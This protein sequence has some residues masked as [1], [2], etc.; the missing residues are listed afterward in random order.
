MYSSKQHNRLISLMVTSLESYLRTD[1]KLAVTEDDG[2]EFLLQT[3][4]ELSESI[5]STY[6]EV[7]ELGYKSKD[8]IDTYMKEMRTSKLEMLAREEERK[9]E[10]AELEST[11]TGKK[12][13]KCTRC[14]GKGILNCYMHVDY[15]VCYK[16]NGATKVFSV[17]YKKHMNFTDIDLVY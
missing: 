6:N 10:K 5:K 7:V 16:C 9:I 11:F 2:R 17:E 3:K 8:Y 4:K 12:Y 14:K 13:V 15:G 1:A